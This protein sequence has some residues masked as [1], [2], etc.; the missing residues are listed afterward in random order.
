[1]T[2]I[3]IDGSP[4]RRGWLSTVTRSRLPLAALLLCACGVNTDNFPDKY[5]H[6]LCKVHYD[7]E[8]SRF[9]AAY[10]DPKDCEEKIGDNVWRLL[11]GVTGEQCDFDKGAARD[12]LDDI[13]KAECG[14]LESGTWSSESCT[15][16]LSA[17]E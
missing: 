2:Q 15:T 1:M 14:A 16:A 3:R 12:C 4:S 13:S 5:G 11:G 10:D 17:C 7:C 8:I 6:A 9:E